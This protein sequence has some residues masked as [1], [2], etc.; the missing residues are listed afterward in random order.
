VAE[1]QMEP[2]APFAHSP[3]QD[4]GPAETFRRWRRR[5]KAYPRS[6]CLQIRRR[7]T[8][9]LFRA[10]SLTG[11]RACHAVVVMAKVEC[12]RLRIAGRSP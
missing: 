12:R 10:L 3:N 4:R 9:T 5:R 2:G 7:R 11:L 8:S 6:L 1:V